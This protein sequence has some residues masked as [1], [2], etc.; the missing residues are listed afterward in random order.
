MRLIVTIRA[1]KIIHEKIIE[2]KIGDKFK[3]TECDGCNQKGHIHTVKEV[4]NDVDFLS[5]SGEVVDIRWGYF[6]NQWQPKQGEMIE[7]SDDGKDWI[8]CRFIGMDYEHFICKHDCSN[9]K[10]FF[11]AR[12]IN[13]IQREI[14]ELQ[15]KIDELKKRFMKKNLII[16]GT[17]FILSHLVSI[18]IMGGF[19][20]Q[21]I[22][23]K[24]YASFVGLLFSGILCAI[25]YG[26]EL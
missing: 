14:D 13:T 17:I 11:H 15:A 12:P 25:S 8:E 10:Q 2:M 7:V 21:T 20:N 9:Y 23:S 24:V 3:L 22:E 6:I 26:D 1:K 19:Y 18:Y 16:V 4:L 5:E